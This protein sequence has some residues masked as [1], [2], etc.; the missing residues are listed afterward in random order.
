M[1]GPQLWRA[2]VVE[3]PLAFQLWRYDALATAEGAVAPFRSTVLNYTD[4]EGEPGKWLLPSA[5]QWCPSGAC[6]RCS[7]I[8]SSPYSHASFAPNALTACASPRLCC[9]QSRLCVRRTFLT[10]RANRTGLHFRSSLC[11]RRRR[12]R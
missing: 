10:P 8:K 2:C 1:L 5:V 4:W 12:P 3:A 11:D 9:R 7:N 6:P